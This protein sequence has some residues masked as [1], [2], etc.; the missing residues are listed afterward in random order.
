MVTEKV[1]MR[2]SGIN[3]NHWYCFFYLQDED[4]GMLPDS[5]NDINGY[6]RQ[7][8][9]PDLSYFTNNI[10]TWP[11]N[12]DSLLNTLESSDKDEVTDKRSLENKFFGSRGKRF[13][14]NMFMPMRYSRR[15]S[16]LRLQPKPR[17]RYHPKM[18]VSMRGKR[19]DDNKYGELDGDYLGLS[20]G[21]A[22]ISFVCFIIFCLS[23]SS[24]YI[25]TN[26]IDN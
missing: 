14:F 4:L 13:G 20:D 18:F 8:L 25:S 23:P 26:H 19:L 11:S 17:K 10:P 1:M 2:L 3:Y 7:G 6:Y 21:N 15:L 12:D 9:K 24:S 16:P 5:L 22:C